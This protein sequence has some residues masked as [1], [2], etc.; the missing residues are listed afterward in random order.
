MRR[1]RSVFLLAVLVGTSP[2][3]AE[4]WPH[5]RGPHRDDVVAEDSGW[6]AKAWP[7]KQALWA[8]NVGEGCTSPLV[9]GGKVC[10]LGWADG[11][12][13]V[14][15]LD[16]GTGKELWAGDDAAPRY[17]RYHQGDESMYAGPCSTPEYDPATGLLYTLGI[18]GDLHCRDTRAGGRQVWALNLYD[19]FHAGKRPA[20][21]R[22]PRRDY[23]YTSSPLVQ[24]DCLLVEVG[25]ADGNL[26]ALDKRTGERRWTSR[27]ADPAGHTGGPVPI[28]VDGVPCVA[29]LTLRRLV[30]VRLDKGHEGETAAEYPW[31]TTYGNNVA[32]PAV[33]GDCVL[34]TSDY[35]HRSV[36]K[37]R[38]TLHGAQRL[39]E[40]PYASKVCTPVVYEGSV[41]WSWLTVKCL[42][43]ETGELRW[44]GGKFGNPGSCVVTADGR[45]VVLGGQGRLALVETAGRSPGK[46]TELAAKDG[47]LR[48]YAW[49]HV[50][51]AG[52]RLYCKDR[53]GNLTCFR[54]G[55]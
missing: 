9:T 23:G 39:W 33:H 25:A 1:T 40:Q 4:D 50:V 53:R 20:V 10:C 7:P 16:A 42:D 43:W 12:D 26:V 44:E 45:L 36:C 29:V 49:P 15:C 52:G 5:W 28:T 13:T 21:G 41:Y 30:V 34:I 32:C 55:P 17:G 6:D 35:N 51:L 24:G 48:D 8:K 14:R 31:A 18:D 27:C 19:R 3:L 47:L 22:S 54:L 38:V 11:K 2:L 37:L 46:Y